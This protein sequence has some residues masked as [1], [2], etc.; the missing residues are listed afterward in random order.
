MYRKFL[1]LI[2]LLIIQ[3]F[4]INAQSINDTTRIIDPLP[5][6]PEFPGGEQQLYCF[7]DKNLNKG[8]LNMV[9]TAGLVVAEFT[10]N[11]FGK[12]KNIKIIKPLN[13]VIDNELI[14][15]LKLMPDWIPGKEDNKNVSMKMSFPL[16]IPYTN[17]F[18]H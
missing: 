6:L 17:Q 4:K 3:F 16:R 8:N 11:K 9:D 10:V 12:V 5:M 13:L 18:C 7:I 2:V 15:I 14:R 1:F